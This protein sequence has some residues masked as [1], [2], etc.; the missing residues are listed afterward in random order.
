MNFLRLLGSK[1]LS[2]WIS[3]GLLLNRFFSPIILGIVYFFVLT[4]FALLYRLFR[5]KKQFGDSSFIERNI[6]YSANDFL[7]PW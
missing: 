5:S 4:P 1:L 6:I 3:F 2:I 7:N